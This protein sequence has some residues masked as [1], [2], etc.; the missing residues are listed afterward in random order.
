MSSAANVEQ[1]I[2]RNQQ[3]DWSVPIGQ[4]IRRPVHFFYL[5]KAPCRRIPLKSDWHGK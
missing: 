1:S 3:K 4:T 2:C 5:A